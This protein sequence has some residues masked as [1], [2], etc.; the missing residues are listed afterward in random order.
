MRG[1]RKK[2][3]DEVDIVWLY[4]HFCIALQ[5]KRCRPHTHFSACHAVLLTRYLAKVLVKG[6][7]LEKFYH[8]P[9]MSGCLT[10][11]VTPDDIERVPNNDGLVPNNDGLVP[12][13]VSQVSNNDELVPNN[14]EMKRCL[15]IKT[16]ASL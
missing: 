2:V 7:C 13:N 8:C 12:N 10:A 14:D 11:K 15:M 6:A 9:I 1:R 5:L 3:W 16:N 4:R